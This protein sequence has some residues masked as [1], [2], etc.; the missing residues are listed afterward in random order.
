MA[1]KKKEGTWPPL[2]SFNPRQVVDCRWSKHFSLTL[3]CKLSSSKLVAKARNETLFITQ[4]LL[5]FLCVCVVSPFDLSIT[6]Q[7]YFFV[8]CQS[9]SHIPNSSLQCSNQPLRKLNLMTEVNT[10]KEQMGE[11]KNTIKSN[12]VELNKVRKQPQ[13][14]PGKDKCSYKQLFWKLPRKISVKILEK[15]IWRI[16]FLVKLHYLVPGS[17]YLR[18]KTS[19][20][21]NF[22][23]FLY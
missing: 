9:L 12:L 8:R 10:T 14:R 2:A 6:K 21:H 16:S 11:I 19:K 4:K 5:L 18:K 3:S 23:K 15:Y 13:R 22:N 17:F 7:N 20:K 1:R